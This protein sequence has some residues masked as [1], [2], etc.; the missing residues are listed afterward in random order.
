MVKNPSANAGDEDSIPGLECLLDNEMATHS[1][2]LAWE[3]PWTEESGVLHSTGSQRLGHD[4][5]TKQ[6]QEMTAL[7]RGECGHG[8]LL[9]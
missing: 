5:V 4:S 9:P 1:S 8:I 7:W 3:I 2:F 6:Q